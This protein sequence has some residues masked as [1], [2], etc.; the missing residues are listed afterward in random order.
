MSTQMP[1]TERSDM[2]V[3]TPEEYCLR[4]FRSLQHILNDIKNRLAHQ[5]VG[6][7]EMLSNPA[8]ADGSDG[9]S[10]TLEAG[11]VPPVRVQQIETL[12]IDPLRI[13]LARLS[14][15]NK[16]IDAI[17]VELEKV[18]FPVESVDQT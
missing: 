5:V 6:N 13:A 2:P 9:N 1:Q 12:I 3:L 11:V 15:L 7:C 16:I 8:K 18:K 17:K 14:G 4:Q 10:E